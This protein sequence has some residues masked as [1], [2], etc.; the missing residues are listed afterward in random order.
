MIG[1]IMDEQGPIGLQ[2]SVN[3]VGNYQCKVAIDRFVR[4]SKTESLARA[5]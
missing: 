3:V 5:P 4:D 2:D 1:V